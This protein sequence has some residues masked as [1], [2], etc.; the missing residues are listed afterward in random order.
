[1][2]HAEDDFAKAAQLP[3]LRTGLCRDRGL[4]QLAAEYTSTPASQTF[5]LAIAATRKSIELDTD[6][7]EGHRALAFALFH[8]NWDVQGA[9]QE[10]KRAIELN[11]KD[12]EAHQLDATALMALGRLP[13]SVTQIE[14]ARQL[15]PA[16]SS[17]AAD[18]AEFLQQR[19]H[20][21]SHH[22]S[23]SSISPTLF[24]SPRAISHAF[25]SS[26]GS[27]RNILTRQKSPQSSGTTIRSLPLSL[28]R[29]NDLKRVEKRFCLRACCKNS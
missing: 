19:T 1:M 21:G 18:R 26:K 11:P 13:E 25:T 16:S 28:N 12:V 8:W 24:Y 27:I 14:T 23:R 3:E 9:E 10:F 7:S 2:T 20:S 29:G 5:P 4:L 17:I 22:H 15:D 6:L